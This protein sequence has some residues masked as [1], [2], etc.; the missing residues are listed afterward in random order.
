VS[1]SGLFFVIRLEPGLRLSGAAYRSDANHSTKN[2]FQYSLRYRWQISAQARV[3]KAICTT[4]LRS[5]RMRRRWL[6]CNH[7]KVRSASQ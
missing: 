3:R 6:L 5:Q 7:A 2:R 4:G 1:V